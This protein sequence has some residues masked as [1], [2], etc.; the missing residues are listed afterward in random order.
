M[1]C[2]WKSPASWTVSTATLQK[3]FE[4]QVDSCYQ[5]K[6]QNSND[7]YTFVEQNG[8]LYY[9]LGNKGQGTTYAGTFYE[10]DIEIIDSNRYVPKLGDTC[11]QYINL[12]NHLLIINGRDRAILFSGHKTYRDFGFAIG[13]P[14]VS[15]YDVDTEY[16]YVYLFC[17]IMTRYRKG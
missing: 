1:K 17:I 4:K 7:V 10:K 6:R 9:V 8:V 2:W 16:F 3:Y 13:S 11:T 14:T 12:G 15:P 5:W